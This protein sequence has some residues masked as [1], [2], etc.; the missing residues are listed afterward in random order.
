MNNFLI[1]GGAGFI[2]S[3]FIKYFLKEYSD[4]FIVNLDKLTYA[5][6][7]ENLKTVEND[8]NYVFIKGSINNKELL[9]YLFSKYHINYVIN[10]AAESHVDRSI[11]EPEI[12]FETNVNGTL[13]L[14]DIAK[15]YNVKKFIQI[16][17]DEVYGELSKS[18]YFTEDMPLAPN[19]PY[20]ASKAS[21]YI[22]CRAYYKTYSL[23]VVVTRCSNNYGPYQFPEKLMPLIIYKALNNEK[24]PVYGDGT[25]VRDWI[26]VIDHCRAIDTVLKKGRAGEIYNI[27]GNSERQNIEVIR[28][29]INILGKSEDLIQFIEDRLS[30]DKRYAMDISKIKR[31]LEWDLTYTFEEGI[32]ETIDWYL[33]NTDWIERCISGE[34]LKYY[35]QNYV[36][37]V[38]DGVV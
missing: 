26:Y 31:E 4:C 24:L 13:A 38:K 22:V 7:L 11:L 5:G 16:S 15:K 17:T 36:A 25:N 9:D 3:N 14:L 19:N 37:R 30:H 29:I 6:N 23:P 1:T 18:G 27:G 28:L 35:H 34:Y 20:S 2:G 32:K 8:K 33:K 21:A 10:F 12:F